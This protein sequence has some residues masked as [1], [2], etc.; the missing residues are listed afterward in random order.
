[1]SLWI[2]SFYTRAFLMFDLI[3][4]INNIA[5]GMP[6]LVLLALTGLLLTVG[7]KFYPIRHI[8]SGF[9][10]LWRSRKGTGDGD[11]SG[12][13]ALMTSLSA[14]IG[15]GNIAGVATAIAEIGRAS[16]RE[17]V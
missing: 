14:T 2:A 8:K 13:N 6:M 1:M 17:R 12:F 9:A 7:L 10:L 16:C 11:I 4:S 5:W 15:T 3:K